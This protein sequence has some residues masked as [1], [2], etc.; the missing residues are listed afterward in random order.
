MPN[1]QVTH[2][3]DAWVTVTVRAE[4]ED[5]ARERIWNG[6]WERI[7]H[8]PIIVDKRHSCTWALRR[9]KQFGEPDQ[10][11]EVE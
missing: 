9:L 4:N 7:E 6:E 5:E 1:Y 8:E 11:E 10:A 3:V 2:R